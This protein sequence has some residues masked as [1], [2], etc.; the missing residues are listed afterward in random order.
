MIISDEDDTQKIK[1]L[2]VATPT[3]RYPERAASRRPFSPL[4]DYET[5]QALALGGLN[6]SQ[7][8]LYKPPLRRRI[9]DSRFW[10]ATITSLVVY[11]FLT[12]VIGVPIIVHKEYESEQKYPYNVLTYAVVW[13]SKNSGSYYSGDINNIS[14]PIQSG[15]YPTCNNWT[16]VEYGTSASIVLATTERSVSPNGQFSI[17]SNASS[18]DDF[19]LVQGDFYTGINPNQNVQDA[20]LSIMMQTS[21]PS[22]FNRNFV[23]F[24]IGDNFTNLALYVPDNLTATDNILYNI[25]LLFPQAAISSQVDSFSTFLPMFDQRFGSFDGNYLQADRLLVDTSLESVTGTFSANTSLLV[26]TI[27]AP[28]V[29]NISLYNNPKSQFPTTLDVHTGNG[30]LTASVTVLAPNKN[31][32]LRPNFITNFRTFSGSLSTNLMHDPTSPP[33]AIQLH[34]VND[35]GPV[36][37]TLDNLFEGAFQVSTKQATASVTQGDAS[38]TD[39]WVPGQE[40]TMAVDF[41][42]TT[43]SYGWIGWGNAGTPWSTYQQGEALIDSSL[44]DV[45]LSFL[46]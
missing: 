14:S 13:P 44:A 36:D 10:R 16:T 19:N 32:P 5:S 27:M 3:V 21:S 1:D 42:S 37:V 12:L 28:I 20:V 41:N 33:T 34:V 31:P 4:P 38:V 30:N 11:I 45:S 9:L 39:P 18:T 29:A 6:D 24:A 17:T 40:R 15:I 7:V 8:T 23:C 46:G 2:P 22:V 26:S 25:T 35:L 43:R